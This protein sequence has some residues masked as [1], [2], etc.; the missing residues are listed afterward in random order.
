M[1]AAIIQYADGTYHGGGTSYL[2][3]KKSIYAAKT[4]TSVKKA[5]AVLR[6]LLGNRGRRYEEMLNGAIVW[7]LDYIFLK[8]NKYNLEE[9]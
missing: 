7:E 4:Y 8:G 5:Q 6:E 9:N 3:P 2:N 1:G